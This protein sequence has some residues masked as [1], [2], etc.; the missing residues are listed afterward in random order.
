MH[1]VS[2]LCEDYHDAR[3]LEHKKSDSLVVI[4]SVYLLKYILIFWMALI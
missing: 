4:W 3:S 1:L 2:Y